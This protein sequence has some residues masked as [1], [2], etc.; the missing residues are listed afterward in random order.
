MIMIHKICLIVMVALLAMTSCIEDGFETSASS[1]PYFSTDTISLGDQFTEQPTPTYQLLIHNPHSK[2]LNLS[3]VR[4]RDGSYFRINVDG[5]SG[6]SFSNIEIRPNDSIYVFVEATLP[7]T[8]A[9]TA[10]ITDYIDVTVNGVTQSVVVTAHALNVTRLNRAT[11]SENTAFTADLPYVISDTLRVAQGATL[12]LAEGTTL[13]FHDKAALIVDGTLISQGSAEAPVRLRG[14][15]TG[16]VVADI[17][18]EVMSNQWEGV[19][20]TSTSTDNLLSH[21]SIANMKQGVSLDS[22]STLTLI[23]SRISNC[24]GSTL[25]A[26]AATILTIIGSEISNASDALLQLDGPCTCTVNR[27]TLANWYLFTYPGMAIVEIADVANTVAD[28]ANTVIYGRGDPLNEGDLTGTQIFFRRCMFA[29]GGEDDS[30]FLQ[31]FWETDP[32]LEYSL[33][34]YTFSYL[35]QEDSPTLDA[36]DAALD[37]PLLPALD[38]HGRARALTLG[39]YAS[40]L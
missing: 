22:L 32:L 20:F 33:T 19:R 9:A 21:T 17:D 12:T 13:Y 26:A 4:L 2:Q 30:N 34:E 3:D 29:V 25:T 40:E 15:R 10:D 6:S 1:Q 7:R 28:F 16:N 31:C 35:P 38:F 14:D 39:A 24:G 37:H 11:I 8:A 23:N 5:T 36:A 18:Y 27:C